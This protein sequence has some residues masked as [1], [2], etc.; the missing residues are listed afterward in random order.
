MVWGAA[1][2]GWQI[3]PDE[4]YSEIFTRVLQEPQ[5]WSVKPTPNWRGGG[6]LLSASPAFEPGTYN[7]YHISGFQAEILIAARQHAIDN[8]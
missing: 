5:R 3:L 8:Q 6:W 4:I 1:N 2:R 7:M